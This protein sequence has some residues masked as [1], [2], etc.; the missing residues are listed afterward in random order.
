MKIQLFFKQLFRFHFLFGVFLFF[1]IQNTSGQT[2]NKLR[3]GVDFGLVFPK[4]K[5]DVVVGT[6]VKYNITDRISTGIRIEGAAIAK[7]IQLE[8][9]S[10]QTGDKRF[11]LSYI[12]TINYFFI[13]YK[14][15][16]P[17]VEGGLGYYKISEI[18]ESIS[19]NYE[20]I[21]FDSKMGIML[22]AGIE[23]EKVRISIGYHFLPKSEINLPKL[24]QRLNTNYLTLSIGYFIGGEKK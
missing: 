24:V 3:L 19:T 18:S 5:T 8:D 6:N 14:E 21:S 17:F 20:P 12:A 9:G 13:Q 16:Y 2:L 22:K 23:H 4:G 10:K 11:N 15:I 7:E 1:I